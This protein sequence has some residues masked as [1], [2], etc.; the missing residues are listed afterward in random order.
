MNQASFGKAIPVLAS[1]DLARTLDFYKDVLGFRT[2]HFEDFSYGMAMRGETELHFWACNDKHI[3]E[4]TSCYIRVADIAVV[5][6]ELSAKLPSIQGVVR[7]AWGMDELYV[8]DPDGNL[9]KFGQ[10]SP[11]A[12]QSFFR[13]HS[14]SG[15]STY[16]ST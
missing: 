13:G 11:G 6:K 4:N 9:I 15:P 2:R 7:T 16:S 8:I 14:T 12:S 1:L 3:A 5:H 10:E